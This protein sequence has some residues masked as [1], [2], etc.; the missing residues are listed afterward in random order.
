[1]AWVNPNQNSITIVFRP[2]IKTD[3][4]QNRTN[5]QSRDARHPVKE[6]LYGARRPSHRNH[7]V[8]FRKCEKSPQA[9]NM[10][11]ISFSPFDSFQKCLA[12]LTFSV[13][14]TLPRSAFTARCYSQFFVLFVSYF[15]L[16]FVFPPDGFQFHF[17]FY[18]IF[19]ILLF[20]VTRFSQVY[21]KLIF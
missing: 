9:K 8:T 13:E 3:S 15:R 17:V 7:R 1:M 4:W 19:L 18:L 6:S 21:Y 14:L 10:S 16:L 20:R 12:L 2:A 11:A 5:A